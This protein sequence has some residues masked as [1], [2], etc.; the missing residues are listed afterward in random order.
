[1][2]PYDVAGYYTNLKR[3]FDALGV[4][5]TQIGA[6]IFDYEQ[7]LTSAAWIAR[8]GQAVLL[9]NAGTLRTHRLRKFWW[10]FVWKLVSVPVLLWAALT[11]DVFILS[12]KPGILRYYWSRALKLLGKK[13]IYVFHGSNSRPDYIDGRS[14]AALPRNSTSSDIQRLTKKKKDGIRRIDRHANLVVSGP[15]GVH[16]HERFSINIL[17]IGLPFETPQGEPPTLEKHPS[18]VHITH[19]PSHP[20]V[21]GTA[22][23]REVVERLQIQGLPIQYVEIMNQ[24]NDVVLGEL[25]Q[26]DFVIDQIYSDSLMAGFTTE[27]AFFGKPAVVGTY[28][29]SADWDILQEELPP[30]A[31]C[32]PDHLEE[33]VERLVLEPEYRHELGERARKFVTEE[34]SPRRVAERYLRLIE[35]DIPQEWWYDPNRIRYLHG[36]GISE[37]KARETV[38]AVIEIAGIEALQLSDKPELQRL[39]EEFASRDS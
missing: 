2:G 12:Y 33:T 26:C 29:T 14:L 34:W 36:M 28:A 6:D 3:G 9:R 17:R 31:F 39:F 4:P 15:A 30:V 32:H 23:I 38:R 37:A 8:M 25:Q 27:A 13:V 19:A 1:M 11:H 21:K 24:P 20:V 5:A 18:L 22:R 16:F 10:R 35:G 7:Q